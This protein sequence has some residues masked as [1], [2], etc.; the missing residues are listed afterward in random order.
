MKKLF[1]ILTQNW[2]EDDEEQ[3][4]PQDLISP[5][6]SVSSSFMLKYNH[7]HIGTLSFENGIWSFAYSE[8]FRNQNKLSFIIGFPSLDKVYQSNYLWSFFSYRIPST[9]RVD[10]QD[11]IKKE[12][13]DETNLVA[14]LQRFG[15]RT[16][17]NPFTLTFNQ[18]KTFAKA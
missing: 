13:I 4:L 15:Q 17:S 8:E 7:L 3:N 9:K 5:A 18:D 6:T 1:K 2:W 10:I 14:L 12:N 11:V 16:I